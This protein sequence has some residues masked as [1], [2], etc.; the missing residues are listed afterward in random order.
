MA[1]GFPGRV[2]WARDIGGWSR[3]GALACRR[4]FLVPH[5][6]MGGPRTVPVLGHLMGPGGGAGAGLS[7]GALA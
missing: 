1:Q 2:W 6:R 5:Q 4:E 3:K 7:Q